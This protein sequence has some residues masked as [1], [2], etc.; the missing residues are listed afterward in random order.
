MKLIS[1]ETATEGTLKKGF[2]D[3]FFKSSAGLRK[4]V[5]AEEKKSPEH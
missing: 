5:R 3:S 4:K 1:C 2:F